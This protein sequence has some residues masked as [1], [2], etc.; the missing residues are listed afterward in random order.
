MATLISPPAR[1]TRITRRRFLG[2]SAAA[3]VGLLYPVE[4]GRHALSIEQHTLKLNRLPEAFRGMRVVQISDFHYEEFNEAFFLEHVVSEVNR[5]K[6]DVVLLTGDFVSYGPYPLSYGKSRAQPCAEK[7]SHIACAQKFAVLGNHDCVVSAPIVTEAVES[8]GIQ[9]LHNASL[10]LERD[11]KRIWLTGLGSAS[12]GDSRPE[13]A[14]PKSAARDKEPILL[15]SHEPDIA[16]SIAR[17]GV[18][19]MV[20]GHTH[21]G[22]IRVPFLTSMFLP[23]LGRKY[24]E[25]LFHFGPMQLYVNRGIGAA[26]LPIRFNCP[27]EITVFTLI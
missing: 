7:L 21:G 23:E 19:L 1:K 16:P 17:L 2:L 8:H 20:S 9:M 10:P 13:I 27:P 12:C 26:N 6:P 11:G 22:Q 3:G 18:D 25:G 15:M 4:I 5:L 14:L 24:V